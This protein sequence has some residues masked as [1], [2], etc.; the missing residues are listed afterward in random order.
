[1]DDLYDFKQEDEKR[2][3]YKNKKALFDHRGHDGFV[4]E[5]MFSDAF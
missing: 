1:L 3:L 5:L 4:A 2:R